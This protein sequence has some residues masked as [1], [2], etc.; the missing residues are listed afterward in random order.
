[1]RSNVF[2]VACVQFLTALRT[3][4]LIAKSSTQSSI[5]VT[6]PLWLG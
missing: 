5:G 4:G 3:F 6:Q 2:D 1:M